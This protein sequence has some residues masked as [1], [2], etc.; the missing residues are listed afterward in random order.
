MQVN[1]LLQLKFDITIY[2]LTIWKI[3][4]ENSMLLELRKKATSRRAVENEV[5]CS[6]SIKS[7]FEL[8]WLSGR[9]D[10]WYYWYYTVDTT[11]CSFLEEVN[12]SEWLVRLSCIEFISIQPMME[13]EKITYQ[14]SRVLAMIEVNVYFTE[15]PN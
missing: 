11:I 7:H 3:D 12:Y 9:S 4:A 1:T 13:L 6:I 14:I 15:L 5:F 8:F 10:L 2:T